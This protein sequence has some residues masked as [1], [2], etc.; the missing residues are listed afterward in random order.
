MTKTVDEYNVLIKLKQEQVEELLSEKRKLRNL[1]NEY[2]NIIHRTTHFNNQL[3]ERYYD[4]QL[5]ISIE[6][7]NTL[8]HS[9]Q[10]LLMEELYNQQNDLDKDIRRLNEDLED[11]ERERYF[12][13]QTDHERR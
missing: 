4:S 11:I 2:E 13:S 10:R 7:N 8:F 3:I 5:F 1:E 6:Q 12:A 9:Q